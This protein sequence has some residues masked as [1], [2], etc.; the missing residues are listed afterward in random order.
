MPII[1]YHHVIK[2]KQKFKIPGCRVSDFKHQ[3]DY[4]EDNYK[5]VDLASFAEHKKISRK[6]LA[7]IIFDDG[8]QDQY[9]YAFP[10]LLKRKIK[11]SFFPIACVFKGVVPVTIKLH[12][13]LAKSNP[14]FFAEKLEHYIKNNN[15]LF[16]PT[17][18]IPKDYRLNIHKRLKDSVLVANIK[19]VW[20]ELPLEIKENFIT[21]WFK[22]IVVSEREFCNKFF[23]TPKQLKIM[24]RAGLDIGSHGYSHTSLKTLDVT[25]QEKDIIESKNIIESIIDR[26]IR[27]FSY[28]FGEYNGQTLQILNKVG[29]KYATVYNHNKPIHTISNLL[30]PS[31]DYEDYI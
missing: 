3:L 1:D 9:S 10:E 6:K 18:V 22:K 8:T 5:T 13:V 25:D 2:G 12:I 27:S 24:S 17:F 31:G 4:L 28:P 20:S 26:P 21:P 30:I 11:A 15:K 16:V 19:Q 23:I 29:F 14:K 7:T